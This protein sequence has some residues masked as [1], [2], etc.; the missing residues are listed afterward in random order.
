T[1]LIS[2]IDRTFGGSHEMEATDA[3][4]INA[5]TAEFDKHPKAVASFLLAHYELHKRILN[6]VSSYIFTQIQEKFPDIEA[7][8]TESLADCLYQRYVPWGVRNSHWPINCLVG[9]ESQGDFFN[10]IIYGVKSPDP[11]RLTGENTTYA[12]PARKHLNN[13]STAV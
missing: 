5:V 7:T 2:Y 13:L 11:S 12:S 8:T 6:E 9:I 3:P 10:N 1:D 4:Y